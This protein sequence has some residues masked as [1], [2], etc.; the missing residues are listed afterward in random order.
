[1][2]KTAYI[3]SAVIILGTTITFGFI[4][5]WNFYNYETNG[6]STN[7]NDISTQG[8]NHA[9]QDY[10]V[11]FPLETRFVDMNGL[12]RRIIGQHEMNGVVKLNNGYLTGVNPKLSDESMDSYICE[13]KEYSD[14][15][16]SKDINMLYVQAPFKISKYNTE[17]PVGDVDFTNENTDYIVNGLNEAGISTIDLRTEMYEDGMNQYD[18][19]FKTDHHWNTEAGFYAYTNIAEWITEQTGY[20]LDDKLTNLD[21][22]NINTYEDWFGTLG[23][24]T[25]RYY[26][27]MDDYDLIYPAFDTEILDKTDGTT[28]TFVDQVVM[29]DIFDE[30]DAEKRSYYD[31][32]YRKNNYKDLQSQQATLDLSVYMISDSYGNAVSPFMLLSY[33]DYSIMSFDK[34]GSLTHET[35]DGFAPDVVVFMVWP[36]EYTEEWM[37]KFSAWVK[38]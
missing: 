34:E 15:C 35:L 36:G 4:G 25:G 23:H 37:D 38:S 28:G 17:L 1:M 16:A 22:Y 21:S 31:W 14:Y 6:I 8:D 29:M 33:K 18:Y 3:G 2:K 30:K 20:S 19:F 26:A 10:Y 27:G 12:V 32:A 7:V 9:K 13:V 11:N 5:A 24:R